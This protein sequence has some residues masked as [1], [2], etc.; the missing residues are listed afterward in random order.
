MEYN[1]EFISNLLL[2]IAL[3]YE[4]KPE[5]RSETENKY[6]V[7]RLK[8]LS[9]KIKGLQD[10]IYQFYLSSGK[11][12]KINGMGIRTETRLKELF[13]TG[14]SV[15]YDEILSDLPEFYFILARI[16]TPVK[17]YRILE[18]Y[19][20]I[21]SFEEFNERLNLNE[22]NL[23]QSI[24]KEIKKEV[25]EYLEA[26][27]APKL[28]FLNDISSVADQL[29][30]YIKK[31]S[32][33]VRIRIAGSIR[34]G[35]AVIGDIDIAIESN[36]LSQTKEYIINSEF[37][38]E[39]VS[40]GESWQQFRLISGIFVDVRMTTVE[41]REFISL[42][43]HLTGSKH[44]NILLR[45][46][47]K[48][49]NFSISEHGVKNLTTGQLFKPQSEQQLYLVLEL[50][51]IP[52]ELRNETGTEFDYNDYIPEDL[53]K[54]DDLLGDFHIHSSFKINS[55]H[56]YGTGSILQLAKEAKRLKYQYIAITDHNPKQSLSSNEMIEL[57]RRRQSEID[58]AEVETSIRIFSSLEID[59]RVD[60]TL[61]VDDSVLNELDFGIVGIHSSFDLDKEKMTQR[62]IRGLSHP[63]IKMLVHPTGRKLPNERKEINV[64]W[65]VILEFCRENGKIL[66]I[67]S[68]QH[69]I[70]LPY[71]LIFEANIFGNLF[72]INSDA[73]SVLEMRNQKNGIINAR[74]GWCV[75]GD[76]I[77]TYS[78]EE[79]ERILL[80]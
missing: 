31:S 56:D 39:V 58:S 43:H 11:I 32:S 73:H 44:H 76:V 23:S 2:D 29:V 50:N 12:P 24:I 45:D 37:I 66:E 30:K 22:L 52:P 80:S 64:D 34:R 25:S 62:I 51:Y 21:N 19:P 48:S 77:N 18:L 71:N 67:N 8:E 33:V 38:S 57:L 59:I 46:Y 16:I 26:I 35:K 68:N 4:G 28:Y 42:L 63:K 75:N 3:A 13:Q 61:A 60:G 41:S 54:L 6:R 79:V 14:H 17:A 5:Y 15:H 70:D 20:D 40:S 69:R 9:N 47:A 78:L 49:L 10:S 65:D 55:S 72:S 53:I 36:D 1:N 27:S 7:L 74:R